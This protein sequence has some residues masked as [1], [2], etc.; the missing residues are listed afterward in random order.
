[1]QS[2]DVAEATALC[3]ASEYSFSTRDSVI[4]GDSN[5]IN[6]LVDFDKDNI[7]DRILKKITGYVADPQFTPDTIGRV[8]YAA[9]SLCLWVQAMEVYGRIYRVVEPKKKVSTK[10]CIY[11]CTVT[12]IAM[13]SVNINASSRATVKFAF[14]IRSCADDVQISRP[15]LN[16]VD[17]EIFVILRACHHHF[18][19]QLT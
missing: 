10:L 19:L 1:M 11:T 14:E 13:S 15:M 16:V 18:S 17:A 2:F 4:P 9:R 12:S 5:F 7:S 8:S 6:D 3:H